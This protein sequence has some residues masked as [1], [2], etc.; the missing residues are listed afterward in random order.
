MIRNL[1]NAVAAVALRLAVK[2]GGTVNQKDVWCRVGGQADRTTVA[3]SLI[4][5]A[6]P[7]DGLGL[8]SADSIET[9]DTDHGTRGILYSQRN[10]RNDSPQPIRTFMF[11]VAMGTIMDNVFDRDANGDQGFLTWEMW[12]GTKIGASGK[13]RGIRFY[14]CV[15]D[16][17]SF[18]ID[19]TGP[20]QSIELDI[21]AFVNRKFNIPDSESV[22]STD[23]PTELPFNT[24]GAKIDFRFDNTVD[25]AWSKDDDSVRRLTFTYNNAGSVEQFEDNSATPSLDKAWTIHVPG[26]EAL[27]VEV[28]VALDDDKYLA[29]DQS[30]TIPEGSCRIAFTHPS[31]SSATVTTNLLAGDNDTQT[32]LSADTGNILAGDV[33]ILEEAGGNF[34]VLPVA[35]VVTDTSIDYDTDTGGGTGFDARLALTQPLTVRNL[36]GIIVIPRLDFRSQSAAVRDGNRRVVT[37]RYE[38]AIG[39]TETALVE[40]HF[41][42]HL[43]SHA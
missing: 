43:T 11:P 24:T 23:F 42:D 26:E 14:G 32:L 25:T 38:A 41:Y 31:A 28:T 36:A 40:S 17:V 37:L 39:S 12:W 4:D 13:A 34:A 15:H 10:S 33:T 1:L 7:A 27:E 18:T 21:Q 22:P 16:S 2:P 6:L 3:A 29:L 9:L 19:R 8:T 30:A 20:G 35:A 5:I